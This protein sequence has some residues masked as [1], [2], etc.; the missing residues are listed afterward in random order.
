[1]E[2]ESTKN[3]RERIAEANSEIVREIKDKGR[4]SI[5]GVTIYLQHTIR[6]IDKV[7]LI[8]SKIGIEYSPRTIRRYLKQIKN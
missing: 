4:V 3:I 5:S 6:E 2:R 8:I 7:N 1:M